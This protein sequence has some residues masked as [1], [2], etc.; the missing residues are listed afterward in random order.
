MPQITRFSPPPISTVSLTQRGLGT[1]SLSWSWTP[2]KRAWGRRSRAGATGQLL[3]HLLETRRIK[4]HGLQ[5]LLLTFPPIGLFS[6]SVNLWHHWS[7]GH[8]IARPLERLVVVGC[9]W[10]GPRSISLSRTLSML[11]FGF[12]F[13]VL[14]E[15]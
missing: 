1:T 8:T 10:F 7:G 12:C 13:L 4:E 2:S 3:N 11:S 9:G 6:L 5:C 15:A 14:L